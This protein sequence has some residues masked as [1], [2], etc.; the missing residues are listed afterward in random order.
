M[1]NDDDAANLLKF[2]TGVVDTI[3]QGSQ[4]LVIMFPIEDFRM[5]NLIKNYKNLRKAY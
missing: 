5:F 4:N 1:Q 2:T 3:G